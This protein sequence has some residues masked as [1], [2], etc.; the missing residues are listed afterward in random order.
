MAWRDRTKRNLAVATLVEV[1]LLAT[2]GSIAGFGWAFWVVTMAGTAAVRGWLLYMLDMYEPTSCL[3]CWNWM[4]IGPGAV[5][6][7]GLLLS[8]R[9]GTAR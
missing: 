6:I 5:L 4:V 2:A 9:E 8:M 7:A 3:W 1:A